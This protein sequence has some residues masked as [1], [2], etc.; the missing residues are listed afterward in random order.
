VIHYFSWVYIRGLNTRDKEDNGRSHTSVA[1][2]G[3][4]ES[5]AQW[6]DTSTVCRQ[7]WNASRRKERNTDA[8]GIRMERSSV[9]VRSPATVGE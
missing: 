1:F 4:L 7:V 9:R 5:L 8:N 3:L 2:M 6:G